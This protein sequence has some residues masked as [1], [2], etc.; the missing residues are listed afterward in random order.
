MKKAF[1]F[2]LCILAVCGAAYASESLFAGRSVVTTCAGTENL[3]LDTG[4]AYEKI[5]TS[6]FKAWAGGPTNTVAASSPVSVSGS[7]YYWNNV[8]A[9]SACT[10]NLP[11]I[12]A[13]Q[14]YCF[15]NYAT[16]TGAV[17]VAINTQSG[18]KIYYKGVGGT[19]S[20][21]TLVSGGAAGDF[22]CI[23]AADAT[24]YMVTGAGYGTW[25]N[26]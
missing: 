3:L 19:A 2:I 10:F 5:T 23:E 12:A 25:T 9:S 21:G 11:A 15:G 4:S 24:H 6:N 16:N 22:V 1:A 20:T 18:V 26:N 14:Q 7:G 13:G 8:G 17:T